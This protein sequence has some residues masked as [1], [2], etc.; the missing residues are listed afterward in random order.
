MKKTPFLLLPALLLSMAAGA[1]GIRREPLRKPVV[2]RN[3]TTLHKPVPRPA[4]NPRATASP[5]PTVSKPSVN[6]KATQAKP[7]A[8]GHPPRN[9][10]EFK[11]TPQYAERQASYATAF[12]GPRKDF[13]FGDGSVL[14]IGSRNPPTVGNPTTSA[15][16]S[17]PP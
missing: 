12:T 16:A 8:G 17:P 4:S 6:I 10:K 2:Q 14:H 7:G 3:A 9:M 13:R 11:T 5:A 1:Q 15:P